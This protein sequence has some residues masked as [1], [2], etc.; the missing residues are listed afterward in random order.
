[1]ADGREMV[2]SIRR[3]HRD[4]A[5][6]DADIIRRARR[7][8]AAINADARA[9]RRLGPLRVSAAQVEAD[10][11]A[12]YMGLQVLRE[13]EDPWAPAEIAGLD[14]RE[15]PER[16]LDADHL[17]GPDS[18]PGEVTLR[19]AAPFARPPEARGLPNAR[20]GGA[21]QMGVRRR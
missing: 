18:D 14:A 8:M 17:L 2:L 10:E 1:M 20:P 7:D 9:R 19:P 11:R 6:L 13:M 4:A 16:G 12:L 21:A 15:A 3:K 5:A